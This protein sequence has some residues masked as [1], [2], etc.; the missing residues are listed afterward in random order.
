MHRELARPPCG[1]LRPDH[2]GQRRSPSPAGSRPPRPRRARLRRPARPTGV[3]QLVVN[4]ERR[5]RGPAA[6]HE[7]R[8]E[9]VLRARGEVSRARPRHVNPA[10]RRA[11]SSSRSTALEIVSRST[12]LPF[13][14]DEENVDET[15]R[16]RYR[17]LDLRRDEAAAEHPAPRAPIVGIDPPRRWRRPGF[18]DIQTPILCEADARGRARLPR[19]EPPPEGPL[20]R[21][22][23]VAADRKQ[24]LVIGGF[25]RYYQIAICFR[26]EDLRADRVQEITQLDVEMAFPDQEFLFELMEKM[27]STVWRECIGVELRDAVPAHDL[28]RG[29]CAASARTSRT[30]AS[31]SRSRTRPS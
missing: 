25:E 15:L 12:P 27:V 2:V 4:P 19:A 14:L 16:I 3:F 20:L 23:A 24:L 26:D 29:R 8:N 9:F 17:W 31:G 10:C 5:A 13:Q 21:A 30:C 7:I 6:G 1:E 11:R 28:R 18:V 22:A